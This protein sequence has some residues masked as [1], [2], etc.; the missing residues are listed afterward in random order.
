MKRE[1]AIKRS[2]KYYEY[3]INTFEK[4]LYQILPSGN[5]G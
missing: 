5:R 1:S 2:I 4:A 3:E